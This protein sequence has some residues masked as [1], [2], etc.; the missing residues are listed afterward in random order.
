[1]M[2]KKI[3]SE[4]PRNNIDKQYEK[5]HTTI[6]A[7]NKQSYDNHRKTYENHRNTYENHMNTYYNNRKTYKMHKN[8]D[9]YHMPNNV[10]P[11]EKHGLS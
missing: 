3:S 8:Q 10:I 4:I 6:K 9:F 2:Q 11:I 7:H 5:Q 1:M